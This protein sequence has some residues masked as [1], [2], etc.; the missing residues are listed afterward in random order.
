MNP[1]PR[2]AGTTNVSHAVVRAADGIPALSR[3]AVDS[4]TFTR[5]EESV[6]RVNAHPEHRHNVA[7]MAAVAGYSLF[8]YTRIFTAVAGLPPYQYVLA[9][10]VARAKELLA[11]PGKPIAQ[12]AA[13]T[14]YPHFSDFSQFFR[15][16]TGLTPTQFRRA[17]TTGSTPEPAK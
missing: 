2:P 6:K 10:R 8:H 5:I 16:A 17:A 4:Y 9:V 12:V 13:E 3:G 11:Q 1:A 15:T 7:A 14:G